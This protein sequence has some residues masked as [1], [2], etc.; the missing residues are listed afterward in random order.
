MSLTVTTP[1]LAAPP[2]IEKIPQPSAQPSQ[3][4]PPVQAPGK[5]DLSDSKVNNEKHLELQRMVQQL[6]MAQ[7]QVCSDRFYIVR[8]MPKQSE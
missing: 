6:Y 5:S 4:S 1:L 3:L 8:K 2:N 7:A